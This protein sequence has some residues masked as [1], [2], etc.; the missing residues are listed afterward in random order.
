MKKQL[1]IVIIGFVCFVWFKN[2]SNAQSIIYAPTGKFANGNFLKVGDK[3]PDLLFPVS[4]YRQK[5]IRLAGLK[6]KLILL[7]LWG[8]YC[9]GCIDFMPEIVNLQ[10]KFKDSITIIMVSKN[11]N[12]EVAKCAVRAENVKNNPLPFINGK[13]NLAGYFDYSF[14]PQYVWIDSSGI[15]RNISEAENVTAEN[16]KDFLNGQKLDINVKPTIHIKDAE[17]PFLVQMYPYSGK[18]FYIYSYLAPLDQTKYRIIDYS[19]INISGRK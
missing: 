6:T 12:D 17:D 4:N 18:N 9:G 10:R 11:S 7:D 8:T 2:T 3:I 13:E 19:D 14:V 5:T 16:I 15:V 1:L